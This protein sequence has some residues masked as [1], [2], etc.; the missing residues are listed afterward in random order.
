MVSAAGLALIR[1]HQSSA[2]D[3]GKRCAR[4]ALNELIAG[5][6]RRPVKQLRDASFDERVD[7]IERE[8]KKEKERNKTRVHYRE[9]RKARRTDSQTDKYVIII[10]PSA[11]S[12][13][14]AHRCMTSNTLPSYVLECRCDQS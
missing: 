4:L 11:V 3:K 12:V 13:L 1:I 2:R 14:T 7:T 10:F 8:K 6:S 5:T 9:R